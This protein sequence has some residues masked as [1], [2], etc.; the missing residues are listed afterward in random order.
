MRFPGPICRIVFLAGHV[1]I[2]V[3]CGPKVNPVE[4]RIDLIALTENT[5]LWGVNAKG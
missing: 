5:E 3:S 2:L 4:I 1:K